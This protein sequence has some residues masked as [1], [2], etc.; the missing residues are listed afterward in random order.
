[1]NLAEGAARIKL[2]GRWMTLAPIALLLLSFLWSALCRLLH[3]DSMQFSFG[4]F[5]CLLIS[6]PGGFVWL[7]GW[8]LEGFAQPKA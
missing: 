5:E 4:L 2:I 1:M 7:A 3:L 8:I 6:I